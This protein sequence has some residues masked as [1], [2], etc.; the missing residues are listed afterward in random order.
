[1]MNSFDSPLKLC[2]R[3]LILSSGGIMLKLARVQLDRVRRIFNG[4]E[5]G[6][7]ATTDL[8]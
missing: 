3:Y 5:L 7:V 4:A 1:M 8:L 2:I 6:L